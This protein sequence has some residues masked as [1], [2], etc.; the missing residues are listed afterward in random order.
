M[1]L[2]VGLSAPKKVVGPFWGLSISSKSEKPFGGSFNLT[3]PGTGFPE[4]F[5][6]QNDPSLESL[7]GLKTFRLKKV[8]FLTKMFFPGE[9]T[10]HQNYLL[11]L[12]NVGE[13]QNSEALK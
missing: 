1:G 7:P 9:V 10:E 3:D 11:L 6:F 12:S 5:Q 13:T 8:L 4:T 2:P